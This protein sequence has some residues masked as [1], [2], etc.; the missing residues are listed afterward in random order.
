MLLDDDRVARMSRPLTPCRVCAGVEFVAHTNIWVGWTGPIFKGDAVVCLGCGH[1]E[2]FMT[3]PK[4]FA[5]DIN[6]KTITVQEGAGLGP[7]Q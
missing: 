4:L 2:L 1:V 7:Y 3:E 6:A 5:Q